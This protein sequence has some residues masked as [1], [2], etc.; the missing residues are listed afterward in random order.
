MVL[1]AISGTFTRPVTIT[2]SLNEMTA[3][4]VKQF[5]HEDQSGVGA[6][7]TGFGGGLFDLLAA[8]WLSHTD[9]TTVKEYSPAAVV[10]GVPRTAIQLD[11][12][13]GC[14]A[15]GWLLLP[16]MMKSPLVPFR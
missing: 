2:E 12:D 8:I 10:L 5:V 7:G 9:E 16:T 3:R 11:F 13:D 4:G 15:Y 6:G 14:V 1:F